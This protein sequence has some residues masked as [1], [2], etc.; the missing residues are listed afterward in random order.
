MPVD[1]LDNYSLHSVCSDIVHLTDDVSCISYD[2]DD[3]NESFC[4]TSKTE[5]YPLKQ[6]QQ[7]QN[8]YN[9]NTPM[10]PNNHQHHQQHNH[11]PNIHENQHQHQHVVVPRSPLSTYSAAAMN[12]LGSRR[13]KFTVGVTSSSSSP[14]SNSILP[15]TSIHHPTMTE[16]MTSNN[17][18][19]PTLSSPSLS[20][21]NDSKY[22]FRTSPRRIG[23]IYLSQNKLLIMKLL[24]MIFLTTCALIWTHSVHKDHV[25]S[26][27]LEQQQQQQLVLL[28][29]LNNTTR[30][31]KNYRKL[32]NIIPYYNPS[33]L[34]PTDEMKQQFLLFEHQQQQQQQQ[35]Y[36]S[37][38]D[39][40]KEQQQQRRKQKQTDNNNKIIEEYPLLHIV[41]T[42]FMQEQG[43]LTALGE[44]RLALFHVFS[45]PTIR[46]Q[47]TQ[48]FIW[49]IKTDPNLHPTLLQQLIDAVLHYNSNSNNNNYNNKINNKDDDDDDDKYFRGNIYIVGSNINYRVVSNTNKEIVTN[50]GGWRDGVEPQE[51]ANVSSSKVYTGNRT[52]LEWYMALESKLPLLETRLDADDGLHVGFLHTVQRYAYEVFYSSNHNNNNHKDSTNNNDHALSYTSVRWMFWCSRRHIEWHWTDTNYVPIGSFGKNDGVDTLSDMIT[53]YG[54]VQGVQ[55]NKLC[56]TPGITTGYNVGTAEGSV[57]VYSHDELYKKINEKD[58]EPRNNDSGCGLSKHADCLQFVEEFVFEAIRSRSPTSAGMLQIGPNYDELK[59]QHY[60]WVTYVFWNMLHDSFGS[61]MTRTSLAWMNRYISDHLLEIVT[62]NLDGQCTTGHSCK[63]TAKEEL[64]K[65]VNQANRFKATVV[66][67]GNNNTKQYGDESDQQQPPRIIVVANNI[68]AFS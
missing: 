40:D 61:G 12:F 37:Q 66:G 32:R 34:P 29:K 60:W 1:E 26:T 20:P 13:R 24:G 4:S 23:G 10:F 42:R 16:M 18:T 65:L 11:N 35:Q 68:S 14:A 58:D 52:I 30:I 44:A 33:I 57:P 47:T 48:N 55:H 6:Q 22:H 8:N 51:L 41:K 27:I 50:P 53:T 63:D 31:P 67:N 46:E 39:N 28:S 43:N 59:Q 15:L 2:V 17:S 19:S 5:K 25:N 45:L 21:S 62:D 64:Q 7:Q 49:I 56:I 54:A 36:S 38:H 9:N 3:D